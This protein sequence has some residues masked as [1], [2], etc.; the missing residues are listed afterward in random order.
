MSI[1]FP[2]FCESFWQI[3]ESGGWGYGNPWICSQ[4]G[5]SVVGLDTS[6]LGM[7]NE[8]SFGDRNLKLVETVLTLGG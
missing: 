8:D 4:L 3:I 7:W 2:K 5:R 6:E 1:E